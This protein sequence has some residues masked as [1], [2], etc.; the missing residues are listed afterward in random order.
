HTSGPP[1]TQAPLAQASPTVQPLPSVQAVP[2]AALGLLHCPLTA[3]QVPATW[4][5]S[6]AVQ[7]TG[8]PALHTPA[9]QASLDVQ[10][11][12][13]P[14]A[15]QPGPS[16][17]AGLEHWPVAGLQVPGMWHWS[18]AVQTTGVPGAQV[19]AWQSSLPL[20]ALPSPHGVL[21]ATG[22]WPQVPLGRQESAVQGL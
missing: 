19:P 20:Q 22:V 18:D 2:F 11:L 8:V 14:Q 13:S 21:L 3:S 10:S 6:G 15:V 17:A 16:L 12:S 7:V 4:H 5:W 1:E 9:E